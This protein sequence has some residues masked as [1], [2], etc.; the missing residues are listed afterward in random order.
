MRTPE[1][2][3]A[4]QRV[5]RLRALEPGQWANADLAAADKSQVNSQTSLDRAR[6]SLAASL[7]Q[8]P[9]ASAHLDPR[10]EI[11]GAVSL[12]SIDD[13]DFYEHNPRVSKNPKYAELRQSI[14]ADGI[15]NI[16][17]VTRRPGGTK[18]FPYGGGNTRLAIAKEL[19]GEGDSRFTQLR[20]VIKAWRSEFDV[21]AAH[22]VENE[23]RGDTTF[24]EKALGV[25]SFKREFEKENPEQSLVGSELHRELKKRGMN[26]GVRMIQNFMFAVEHLGAV[27][28]WLRTQDVNTILRP[29]ISE[30]V[31]VAERFDKRDEAQKLLRNHLDVVAT[32][33]HDLTERN[34]LRDASEHLAVELDAGKLVHEVA[35]ALADATGHDRGRLVAMSALLAGDPR[36]QLRD[37]LAHTEAAAPSAARLQ[38]PDADRQPPPAR[39]GGDSPAASPEPAAEPASDPSPP[40]DGWREPVQRPLAPMAGVVAGTSQQADG[41]A[42]PSGPQAAVQPDPRADGGMGDATHGERSLER[43]RLQLREQMV[44]VITDVNRVVPIHDF[45]K[46]IDGM[47]FGFLVDIPESLARIGDVDVT[48][49]MERRGM[50]WHFLASMSGQLHEQHWR[51]VADDPL[52]HGTRWARARDQGAM[53]FARALGESVYAACGLVDRE[54]G[55]FELHI[56]ANVLWTLLSDA[57]LGPLLTRVIDVR[58]SLQQLEPDSHMLRGVQLR[59]DPSLETASGRSAP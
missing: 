58:H 52:I 36:L 11:E 20:V 27:G 55:V 23:N 19:A 49:Q 17:T 16:L 32:G 33:L 24:W 45:M 8:R 18:Y 12:L 42:I 15:T 59:F 37:L 25:Q 35:Q 50:V 57:Q 44:Q 41:R 38:R 39:D 21:V 1:S 4:A 7:A 51:A 30:L 31:D 53:S 28:Q 14:A 54:K 43:R 3:T 48:S 5:E 13:I 34:R 22:L 9:S 46:A 56:P 2:L 10:M 47:P 40:A 6:A 29:R 26:F